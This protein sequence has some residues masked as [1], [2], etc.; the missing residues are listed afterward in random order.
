MSDEFD[1]EGELGVII[2]KKM[3]KDILQVEK[4]AAV[5]FE[6]KSY[7]GNIALSGDSTIQV[8]GV[9]TLLGSPHDITIPMQVHVDSSKATAKAQ[10]VIPYIQWGLKDPSF[11]I[12]KADKDVT[13]S[14]SLAGSLS[15]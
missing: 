8:T 12:W 7:N 13:I 4:Y 15:K 6:P 9:F 11:M 2:D 10:F 14:L 1:Y 5:S 3:D